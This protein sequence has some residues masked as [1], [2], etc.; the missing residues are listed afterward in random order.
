VTDETETLEKCK[1]LLK[2]EKKKMA[3]K[4]AVEILGKKKRKSVSL[5][6]VILQ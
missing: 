3:E 6:F 5:L 1:R 2:D 4:H